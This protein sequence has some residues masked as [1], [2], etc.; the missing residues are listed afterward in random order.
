MCCLGQ[1]KS[2]WMSIWCWGICNIGM[3]II[4]LPSLL[5]VKNLAFSRAVRDWKTDKDSWLDQTLDG[6]LN[7]LLRPSVYFLVKSCF[8]KNPAKSVSPEP[9]IPLISDPPWYLIGLLGLHYPPGD[10]WSPW[11]VFSKE[12]CSVGLAR[13][14]SLLMFPLSNCP[15]TDPHPVLGCK[16]PL[17]QAVVGVGPALSPHCKIPLRCPL[18]LQQWSWI[19][20]ALPSLTSVIDFCLLFNNIGGIVSLLGKDLRPAVHGQGLVFRNVLFGFYC[21]LKMALVAN[22]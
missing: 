12:S 1:W 15:F 18:Y 20:S 10:V 6:L 5:G 7:L 13:T 21:N 17:A 8:S 2:L 14:P 22:T 9:S 16:F 4:S 3:M 19:M 11:P